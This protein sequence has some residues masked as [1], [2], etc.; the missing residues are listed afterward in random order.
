MIQ[1][2][3]QKHQPMLPEVPDDEAVI[4]DGAEEPNSKDKVQNWATAVSV[5]LHDE[6]EEANEV[7]IEDEDRESHFDRHLKDVRV[8]ESPTRPWG[9]P[10]PVRYETKSGISA[11]NSDPTASPLETPQLQEAK[12]PP[13]A[14]CPFDHQNTQPSAEAPKEQEPAPE[15][16][17]QQQQ[18]PPQPSA[19]Q[20][21]ATQ[22]LP[23]PAQM[24]FTGPVFI[25]FGM[26]QALA[27]LQ[28]SGIGGN[29][30]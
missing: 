10:V 22:A 4:E 24:V 12:Q 2:L 8:G 15:P 28:Q 21:H 29:K 11:A 17:T 20:P 14:K 7:A 6:V 27:L 5:S 19:T 25:G 9:I 30:P 23:K 3:G 13:K 26:D 16:P 1:G 18:Q